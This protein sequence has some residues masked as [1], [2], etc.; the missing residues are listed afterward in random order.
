[1]RCIYSV[2]SGMNISDMTPQILQ[3]IFSKIK[4]SHSEKNSLSKSKYLALI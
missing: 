4:D 3:C 1:M 2:Q